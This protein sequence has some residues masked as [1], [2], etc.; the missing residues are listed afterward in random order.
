MQMLSDRQDV[1]DAYDT[2]IHSVETVRAHMTLT[3]DPVVP[4]VLYRLAPGAW[5]EEV[6]PHLVAAQRAIEETVCLLVEEARR[7]GSMSGSQLAEACEV[8]PQR[9]RRW[10]E[11]AREALDTR[12]AA[13]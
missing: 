2:V 9:I 5:M 3:I 11:R 12:E 1:P 10:A 6:L 4:E 8:T 13:A 7:T